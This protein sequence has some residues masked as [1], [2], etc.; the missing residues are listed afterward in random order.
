MSTSPTAAV[1]TQQGK[2]R[3]KRVDKRAWRV[4]RFAISYECD[5]GPNL[6]LN[7][8]FQTC[9]LSTV[10]TVQTEENGYIS[11]ITSGLQGVRLRLSKTVLL[12]AFKA[13]NEVYSKYV[14]FTNFFQFKGALAGLRECQACP[15]SMA[16]A[17]CKTRFAALKKQD[18]SSWSLM[19]IPIPDNDDMIMM[20]KRSACRRTP[21]AKSNPTSYGKIRCKAFILQY[22]CEDGDS[23]FKNEV[24]FGHWMQ[25]ALTTCSS[26]TLPNVLLSHIVMEKKRSMFSI[27]A[28]IREYNGWFTH[29]PISLLAST[30]FVHGYLSNSIS[31]TKF[32][33]IN[34]Y[35]YENSRVIVLEPLRQQFT[36]FA[37]ALSDD[38]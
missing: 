12:D 8:A 5:E 32:N 24:I 22:S 14:K 9:K 37:Q 35:I 18:P 3:G 6:F 28:S 38:V 20:V 13:Y 17:E 21:I 15:E 31:R 4:S 11:F 34:K 2:G 23:C 19:E 26:P 29:A 10:E 30:D 36:S 7:S 25:K 1:E 16:F 27:L 33:T